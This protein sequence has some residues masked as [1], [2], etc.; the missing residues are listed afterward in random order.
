MPTIPLPMIVRLWP[1]L[2]AAR[3]AKHIGQRDDRIPALHPENDPAMAW[4]EY[5][6][7]LRYNP[8]SNTLRVQGQFTVASAERA[9]Q[10]SH[11]AGNEPMRL[12]MDTIVRVGHIMQRRAEDL[13]ELESRGM[14]DPYTHLKHHDSL[15]DALVALEAAESLFGGVTL[16]SDPIRLSAPV[17]G[18]LAEGE[19]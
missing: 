7:S 8:D 6:R 5:A 16:R 10:I 14:Q 19:L 18:E 11:D 12:V 9:S 17:L 1:I 15:H 3:I 13:A 2:H 4:I